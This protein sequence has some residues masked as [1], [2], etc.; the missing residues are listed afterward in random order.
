[1]RN[2]MAAK[3][4][5]IMCSTFV[6]GCVT[7]EPA[8]SADNEMKQRASRAAA[9]VVATYDASGPG[10]AYVISKNGEI[11]STSQTGSASIFLIEDSIKCI[12]SPIFEPIPMYTWFFIFLPFSNHLKTF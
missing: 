9:R 5:A 1:M 8:V 7:A 2:N 6:A 3:I 10:A 11:F 4:V 12:R